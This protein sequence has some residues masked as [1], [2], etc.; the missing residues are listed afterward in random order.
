M[1]RYAEPEAI[2]IVFNSNV[3]PRGRG[4]LAKIKVL[5]S[6]N[7]SIFLLDARPC[8][9]DPSLQVQSESGG[10]ERLPRLLLV[11]PD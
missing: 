9:H 1:G 8:P 4:R 3:A 5:Y 7:C 11:K 2:Y 10:V 6:K